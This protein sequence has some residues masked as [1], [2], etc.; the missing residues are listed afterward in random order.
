MR[1]TTIFLYG[2]IYV[3]ICNVRRNNNKSF[4]FPKIS[5]GQ[6]LFQKQASC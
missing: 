6:G 3:A 1:K 5:K 2:I 4:Y